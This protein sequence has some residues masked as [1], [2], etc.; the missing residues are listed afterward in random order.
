[1]PDIQHLI[2]IE[3]EPA[4]V[5]Q[6]IATELGLK[7]WWTADVEADEEVGGKAQFGFYKRATVYGMRIDD[8][9]PD[10][11]VKWTCETGEEWE[12]TI[13]RVQP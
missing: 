12:G 13:I 2:R 3:A 9:V 7:R 1:M 10:H 8:L 6:E 4:A 5:Y 11:K